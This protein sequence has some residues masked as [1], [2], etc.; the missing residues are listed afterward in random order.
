M[1]ELVNL[2]ANNSL[3]ASMSEEQKFITNSIHL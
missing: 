1:R 2:R 3:T